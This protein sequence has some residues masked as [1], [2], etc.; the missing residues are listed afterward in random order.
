MNLAW[1]AKLFARPAPP[2]PRFGDKEECDLNDS[3]ASIL[4]AEQRH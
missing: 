1:V 3:L 2:K 4:R